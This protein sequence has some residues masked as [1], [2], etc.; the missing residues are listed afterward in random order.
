VTDR[1]AGR[2]SGVDPSVSDRYRT[3]VDPQAIVRRLTGVD[4]TGGAS[5]VE[6]DPI[7]QAA[8]AKGA[9]LVQAFS[10][11]APG[12]R[13]LL[14]VYGEWKSQ[15]AGAA[16]AAKATSPGEELA[17]YIGRRKAAKKIRNGAT[18]AEAMASGHKSYAKNGGR[19][20]FGEWAQRAG[21]S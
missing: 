12:Q 14:E 2:R 16:A 19:A 11:A 10:S 3:P 5:T 7:H 1:T 13:S 17:M 9:A 4:L 18:P 8:A 21:R 20:S 6:S 15:Q